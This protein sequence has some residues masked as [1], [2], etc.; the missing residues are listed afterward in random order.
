[1]SQAEAEK[2]SRSLSCLG[3]KIRACP[4]VP[5]KHLLILLMVNPV[6]RRGGTQNGR[7]SI[8]CAKACRSKHTKAILFNVLPG[9]NT[10]TLPYVCCFS[11]T[12]F[13]LIPT[14]TT[15]QVKCARCGWYTASYNRAPSNSDQ[16]AP[17]V[18]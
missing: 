5:Y 17:H 15:G 3:E 4:L 14:F 2:S 7:A 18:S 12:C 16:T 10:Y 11:D 1:M 6:T 8:T 9:N 13:L